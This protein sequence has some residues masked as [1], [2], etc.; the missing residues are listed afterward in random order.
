MS[1]QQWIMLLLLLLLIYK[2]VRWQEAEDITKSWRPPTPPSRSLHWGHLHRDF[3]NSTVS[4][5][6]QAGY[7]YHS[8]QKW[9]DLGV[10]PT[11]LDLVKWIKE[12][13]GLSSEVLDK[14]QVRNL[15]YKWKVSKIPPGA[16][17]FY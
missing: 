15:R 5:W 4:L 8:A 1:D 17:G 10:K 13:E 7:D 2:L 9:I 3:N 14:N 12:T 16:M 11:E 6:Q